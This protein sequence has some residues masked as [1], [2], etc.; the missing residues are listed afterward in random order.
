L[1]EA[2]R[3]IGLEANTELLECAK[4]LDKLYIPTRY[5]DAWSEGTPGFYYTRRDSEEAIRCAQAVIAWV[6]EAWSRLSSPGAGGRE[7]GS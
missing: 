2:S 7:R 4:L 6:E 3:L 1:L 5:P